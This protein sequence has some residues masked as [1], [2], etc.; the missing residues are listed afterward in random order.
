MYSTCMG[1][2]AFNVGVRTAWQMR[3]IKRIGE[4]SGMADRIINN[5][6]E[7]NPD[8]ADVYDQKLAAMKVKHFFRLYKLQNSGF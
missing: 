7:Q 8:L 2:C 3:M 6:K 1:S 5:L 4:R